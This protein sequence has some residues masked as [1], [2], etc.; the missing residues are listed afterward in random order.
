MWRHRSRLC[1]LGVSDWR[2]YGAAF[3]TPVSRLRVGGGRAWPVP[4]PRHRGAAWRLRARTAWVAV[5]VGLTFVAKLFLW[6]L[7]RL[8]GGDAQVGRRDRCGRG[9][10]YRRPPVLGGDRLRGLVGDSTL[11]QALDRGRR[12]GSPT[13][14]VAWRSPGTP[15]TG[16]DGGPVARRSWRLGAGVRRRAPDERRRRAR[17]PFCIVTALAA[18]PLLWNHYLVL[19]LA[20]LAL[21]RPRLSAAWAALPLL[22]LTPHLE[23]GH[24]AW[25]SILLLTVMFSL[26]GVLLASTSGVVGSCSSTRRM[27]RRVREAARWKRHGND[28]Q[29]RDETQ[30]SENSA[31]WRRERVARNSPQALSAALHAGCRGFEHLTAHKET[32][33]KLR[34]LVTVQLS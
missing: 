14:S 1:L 30:P 6:P 33:W 11:L 26:G 5:A 19:L 22:W 8:A 2:C 17:S 34:F 3:L 16:G 21:L 12:N 13:R 23:T 20:P 25:R 31:T 9:G 29:Q 4:L 18:T 24:I 27:L 15:I 7:R 10:V 28:S 32:R